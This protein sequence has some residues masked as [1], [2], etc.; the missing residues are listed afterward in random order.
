MILLDRLVYEKLSP[1]CKV[2][3]DYPSEWDILPIISYVCENN[4]C[5]KKIDGKEAYSYISYK[6]D[7]FADND[8]KMDELVTKVNDILMNQGFIRNSLNMIQEPSGLIHTIMRFGV[9]VDDKYNA[10]TYVN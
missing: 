5:V 4:R 3:P 7:I 8:E 2:Y 1:L 6:I 9:Y 10:Y